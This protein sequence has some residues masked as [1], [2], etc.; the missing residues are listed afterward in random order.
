MKDLFY[1][2]PEILL[3]ITLVFVIV[4]EVTY[5]G[6][7]VRLISATAIVGL[8][9][10]LIQALINFRQGPAVVFAGTMA[11]DGM[12]FVF[13]L[14]FII[15]AGLSIVSVSQTKD[16]DKVRRAEC[17]SLIIAVTIAACFAASAVNLL[18]IF[19]ALQMTSLLGG[20]LAGFSKGSTKS[21]EAS[22][23]Y[24]VFAV[25]GSGLL[26]YGFG[27]AFSF[28]KVL[29]LYEIHKILLSDPMNYRLGLSAFVLVFLA[30]AVHMGAFPMHAWVPDVLEG[31]PTSVSAFLALSQ[32]A[33]GFAVA[34]RV[35]FE[36]FAQPALAPAN[37]GQWII[38]GSVDWTKIVALSAGVSMLIGV[39]LAL[40]HESTKRMVAALLVSQTGQILL[41]LM[42][43][44]ATGLSSVL[45]TWFVDLFAV[46][47][48]YYVLAILR[49]EAKGEKLKD[50][51]GMLARLPIESISLILFLVA[52]VGLPPMPGFMSKFMLMGSVMRQGW[53]ILGA[54]MVTSMAISWVVIARLSFAIVGNFRKAHKET[55]PTSIQRKLFLATL[56]VPLIL[57][58]LYSQTVFD[59]TVQAISQILW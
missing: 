27:L 8:A 1:L 34:I 31:A 40:R 7:N 52:I 23:K 48:V 11:V 53:V 6:E 29:S 39:L 37:L 26:I 38:L 58:T 9:S 49:E 10:A 25:V 12:S 18:L 43:L 57:M 20:L 5:F 44:D 32:R 55:P 21:N 30:L 56:A 35:F 24:L 19:V 42:V 54:L 41:G 22:F 17:Y 45:Y 51:N 13:R 59:W 15:L 50:L 16:I 47:G 33:T 3:A 14:F 2:L 28:T 4:G 46:V 36:A